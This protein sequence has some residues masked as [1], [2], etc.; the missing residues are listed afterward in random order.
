M[1][2]IEF[3]MLFLLN[4]VLHFLNRRRKKK[5]FYWCCFD[6]LI[7]KLDLFLKF[8]VFFVQFFFDEVEKLIE[9]FCMVSCIE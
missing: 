1:I 8:K 6:E 5:S 2:E 3:Q 4:W 9:L 7:I